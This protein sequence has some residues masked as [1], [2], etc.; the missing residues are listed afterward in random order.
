MKSESRIF[1]KTA[2]ALA[3]GVLALQAHAA[4]KSWSQAA[5]GYWDVA[6]NW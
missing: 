3:I 2:I 1:V 4:T 6:G 5:D